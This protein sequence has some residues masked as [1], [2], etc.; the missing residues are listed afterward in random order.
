LCGQNGLRIHRSEPLVFKI[1][2]SKSQHANYK[3]LKFKM[4]YEELQEETSLLSFLL[5]GD[6]VH[7]AA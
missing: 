1:S 2:Q 4:F 5:A 3:S 7:Q 6:M